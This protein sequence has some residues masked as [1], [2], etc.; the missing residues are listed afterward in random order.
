MTQASPPLAATPLAVTLGAGRA[1]ADRWVLC[2]VMAL[3]PTFDRACHRTIMGSVPFEKAGVSSDICVYFPPTKAAHGLGPLVRTHTNCP[4]LGG[5]AG[6]L[7]TARLGTGEAD[8][9]QSIPLAFLAACIIVGVSLRGG[10]GW[11]ENVVL[12]AL[13]IV[14]TQSG[15]N[16]ARIESDLRTVVLG[17]LL[18]LA[19]I[20]ERIRM[21]AS[22]H[23]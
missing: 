20:A 21:M 11:V 14:L 13:F 18:A 15:M 9:G 7:L 10:A 3:Q 23:D 17:G 6:M 5:V 1:N 22:M 19:V 16:L 2:E 8:I 12:G 4:G